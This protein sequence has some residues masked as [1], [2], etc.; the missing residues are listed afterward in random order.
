[1]AQPA[2]RQGADSLLDGLDPEQR[3]VATALLGPVCVLAGAGTGKTRAITHRIAYGVRTGTYDPSS[4]L[5]V[6]FTSRAAGELRQRLRDLGAVGV[7]ARTFHAAALRQLRYF[8]PREF[9]RPVPHIVEH[10]AR[11]VA[12]AAARLGIEVDR[13][14]VRDMAAE[15][16]WSKVHLWAPDDY[17]EQAANAGRGLVAGLGPIAISRLIRSYEQLL[18]EMEAMDFEDVLLV[19]A[20]MMQESPAVAR[21]VRAQYRYFVVDEYQDVSPLQQ[22]LLDL[23]LG[24]S[25][26]LCVVGDPAQTIYSFAGATS[27]YLT[28][29]ERR[30]HDATVVEL[31]RD[32]RSTPQVVSLANSLLRRGRGPGVELVAQ[33]A[34]GPAVV[35]RTFPDDAAEA[36]GIA[37]RIREL[38]QEGLDPVQIAVLYRT[39][40]QSEPL[41]NALANAALPYQVRG[42]EQ[43]FARQEV[44]QAMAMLRVQAKVKS[45]EPVLYQVRLILGG[46][47]WSDQAPG[48]RGAV[49]E[50]WE[51]LDALAALAE[52]LV[53]AGAASLA[54]IVGQI[55]ERAEAGHTP[56]TNGVTLAS[57]HSAKGLEWEAVFLAGMADGLMPISLATGP[58]ELAEERRL[59]YVGITRARRYLE[60]SYAKAR[61]A[62]GNANR[63]Y[64]PFLNGIWP[65]ADQVSRKA[66]GLAVPDQADLTKDQRELF[67][68]LSQWRLEVAESASIADFGVMT[69]LTLRALAV[70]KPA[71]A[72]ELAGVPGLGPV[73]IERYGDALLSVLAGHGPVSQ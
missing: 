23:W 28:G 48:E 65:S 35:F 71:N 27:A 66:R 25:R 36:A 13:A 56:S 18:A 62:A 50:R 64:S 54:D 10:K 17:L 57:L 37:Q 30:Y 14:A 8:L 19:M 4:V 16:E 70:R 46:L 9:K 44:R 42:G 12:Q 43:F 72:R 39:N 67:E 24:E 20:G 3:A 15:I 2:S 11:L 49:R 68:K 53:L 5:A 45:D 38:V 52:E 7:Q 51:S 73:K 47:G 29:F 55:E 58:E 34:S 40:S 59:L 6:T 22:R 41:E 69:D 63:R 31:V 21:A 26:Q 1:M 32:Y 61:F 60:L 33:L